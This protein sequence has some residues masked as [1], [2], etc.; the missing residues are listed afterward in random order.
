MAYTINPNLPRLRAKAVNM[1]INEHKSI[2]HVAR[3]YGF[4]PSTI[5]RWLKKVPD[6]GCNEI[7]TKSSR[8]HSH[9]KKISNDII[10][11][12]IKLRI[13]TKG[14]CSEVIHQMLRNEGISISLN[15]VKRTLDRQHLLKKRSPWKRYHI[16]IKRPKIGLPGDLIQLDTIHLM[17]NEKEKIYV[18]T[19]IDVYS[20]WC[21]A[22]A[23]NKINT[24]KTIEFLKQARR[25]ALFSFNC[26]QSDHGSEFSQHF[27]ERIN[28]IH[29][30]S[31]VRCPND[32][33]HLER[34]NR[35]LQDELLDYLPKD[36][37]IINRYLSRYLKYYN[38]ERLHLGINLKTPSQMIAKC[39]QAIG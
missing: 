8:P 39:C 20:R 38:E 27:T 2:R 14:R 17:K 35:T 23:V 11:R 19:L 25:K 37:S 15:S 31:R 24:L 3:Y 36:V 29:R 33:A 9:P 4:N 5:S 34:F 1:V 18:Y 26:I 28:I 6:G 10:K 22:K 7:P 16:S 21:Y 30:H 32:N 13:E 12:I